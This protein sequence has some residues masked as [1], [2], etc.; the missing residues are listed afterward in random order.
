MYTVYGHRF[1]N[2]KMY[3]G[4]TKR[5]L[6][7]RFG[8]NG[9]NYR[10]CAA[11]YRAIQE[12]GWENVE[13]FPIICCESKEDAE[14]YEAFLIYKKKTMDPQYGYNMMPGGKVKGH[15]PEESKKRLGEKNKAIWANDPLKRQAAAERMR[16]R[17]SD[18]VYKKRIL[19]ALNKVEPDYVGTYQNR[20]L[21][22]KV[23]QLDINGNMIKVWDSMS[24]VQ[25]AN[26]AR[27]ALVSSCCHGKAKS[28]GGYLWEFY[29]EYSAKLDTEETV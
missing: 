12:F 5:R 1:P 29:S 25:R 4:M 27:S 23:V 28:A 24:E 22:K 21:S 9:A 20:G 6:N 17:M 13:H 16:K 2:G 18:P 7:Q 10:R 15:L 8:K 11:M 3:I 19:D 26:I 14:W